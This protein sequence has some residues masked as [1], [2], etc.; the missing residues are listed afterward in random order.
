MNA[1]INPRYRFVAI[2]RDDFS[3]M[4]DKVPLESEQF[5]VFQSRPDVKQ[6]VFV[7]DTD[8]GDVELGQVI[9]S[10]DG[11][12]YHCSRDHREYSVNTQ[13]AIISLDIIKYLFRGILWFGELPKLYEIERI[14]ERVCTNTYFFVMA[15]DHFKQ[16]IFNRIVGDFREAEPHAEII[17][18]TKSGDEVSI[19]DF[20]TGNLMTLTQL[21]RFTFHYA[22]FRV[23]SSSPVG[24]RNYYRLC[25][26]LNNVSWNDYKG[27]F[28][29]H[30][31]KY[32][33]NLF[34]VH[35]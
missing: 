27:E 12:L 9:R 17:Y 4:V 23:H 3:G 24:K 26:L 32:P 21:D 28:Q 11:W 19:S 2:V 16:D 31:E 8:W 33:D 6:I 30:Y 25:N 22:E 5:R 13:E 34:S 29:R 10:D 14:G 35:D 18:Y 1:K 15:L 7:E 20:E